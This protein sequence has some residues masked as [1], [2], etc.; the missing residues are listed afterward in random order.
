ME[1][2]AARSHAGDAGLND[3]LPAA[4]HRKRRQ[5]REDR[6]ALALKRCTPGKVSRQ[7]AAKAS[8]RS[9]VAHAQAT[10]AACRARCLRLYHGRARD[11]FRQPWLFCGPSWADAVRPSPPLRTQAGFLATFC[12]CHNCL[13]CGFSIRPDSLK[14]QCESC[15]E[16]LLP[17]ERFERTANR[18]RLAGSAFHW[19]ADRD[20]ERGG[21]GPLLLDNLVGALSIPSRFRLVTGC[22]RWLA[23]CS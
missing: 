1:R 22:R 9:R 6:H 18:V 4:A 11:A 16:V 7:A 15:L 12:V 21:L 13:F 17:V 8:A 20:S 5:L 19:K 23:P 14:Q 2:G 10:A 3:C